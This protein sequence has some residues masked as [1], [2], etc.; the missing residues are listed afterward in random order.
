MRTDFR[1]VDL[2]SLGDWGGGG[3]QRGRTRVLLREPEMCPICKGV[4]LSL[5]PLRECVDHEGL[6]RI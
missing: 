6:D 5:Y 1:S 2:T 4:F 3:W